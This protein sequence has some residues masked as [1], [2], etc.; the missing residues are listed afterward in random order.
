MINFF[1]YHK[2]TDI[3]LIKKINDKFDICDTYLLV[4]SYNPEKNIL[5]IG[6]QD[7][8]KN[9]ILKGKMVSFN[10]SLADVLNK[11]NQIVE[12]KF[13][14]EREKYMVDTVWVTKYTGGVFKAYIIY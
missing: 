6:H 12:C 1:F 2:L 8:Y 4:N 13:E 3:D 7:G 10:M 11:I 9:E 14:N 5:N